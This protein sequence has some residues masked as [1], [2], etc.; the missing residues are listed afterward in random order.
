MNCVNG[1]L[2][3]NNKARMQCLSCKRYGK[4]A[5]CPPYINSFKIGRYKNCLLCYEKFKIDNK[6]SIERLSIT[7]SLKLH[8]A[9]IKKRDEL[10]KEGHY[11]TVALGGGS[12]KL[13]PA[14]SFPCRYPEKSLVPAEAFKIDLVEMMK[15]YAGI[16]LVFP[17]K[18]IFY[19]VGVIL[20]D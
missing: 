11:Y 16:K 10:V 17:V 7:S 1:N 5:T 15:V 4:K 13:C 19:R 20:Y 14:C 12:C 6:K 18:N 2:I 3:F 9:L 8:V